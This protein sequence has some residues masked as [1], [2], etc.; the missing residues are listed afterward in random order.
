MLI[1]RTLR[2]LAHSLGWDYVFKASYDK[3]N[4]T[5]LNSPRGPGFQKG[6]KELAAIRKLLKVPVLTDVHSVQQDKAAGR[7]V[8]S[9]KNPAFLFRT[10]D[11]LNSGAKQKKHH[12]LKKGQVPYAQGA[13]RIN[14]TS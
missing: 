11:L 8:D 2:D 10:T 3:A 14:A 7:V 6:L 12:T 4:R 5:S 13:T 9:L 1:G